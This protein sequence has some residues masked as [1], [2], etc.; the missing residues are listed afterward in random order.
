MHKASIC[1]PLQSPPQPINWVAK[2]GIF[3][4]SDRFMQFFATW[5]F[6]DS[7]RFAGSLGGSLLFLYIDISF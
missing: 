5:G 6:F 1:R 7:L 2:V 3:R 4:F